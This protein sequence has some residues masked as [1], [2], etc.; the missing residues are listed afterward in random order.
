MRIVVCLKAVPG[1][2]LSARIA[3]DAHA[4]EYR[5]SSVIINEPDE[6]ALE[7][8]LALRSQ[9]GG[10]VTAITLGPANADEILRTALGKG[11]D[12]A[13]RIESKLGD[14]DTTSLVLAAAIRR[15]DFDLILAGVESWDNM[16]SHVGIAIA[17]RL[18][19]PFVFG[20]NS[21][22]LSKDNVVRVKKEYGG[23]SSH[24]LDITLPALLCIQAGTRRLTS[25]PAAKLVFARR[26]PIEYITTND[27]G[28]DLR[29]LNDYRRPN[30]LAVE[31]PKR[32]QDIQILS[33][34]LD[35][36][37]LKVAEILTGKA[38]AEQK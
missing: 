5:S 22:A 21:L 38:T 18:Q 37:A 26:R 24:I 10:R 3:E 36:V 34:D 30:I 12:Q 35:N 6:F 1:F 32:K 8:A 15:V 27:L 20:V 29:T 16:G 2:V 25:V 31:V 7:E 9:H 13:I 17:N 11:A 33:G 4:I 19:V 28:L 14:P 23:G